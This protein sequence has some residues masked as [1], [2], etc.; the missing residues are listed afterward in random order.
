M[1]YSGV[2]GFSSISGNEAAGSILWALVSVPV[3]GLSAA[4]LGAS[5]G[6]FSGLTDGGP[7][8]GLEWFFLVGIASLLGAWGQD[9]RSDIFDGFHMAFVVPVTIASGVVGLLTWILF[10]T[11][12]TKWRHVRISTIGYLVTFLLGSTIGP[13]LGY[14][15]LLMLFVFLDD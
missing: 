2:T 7:T 12:G 8:A 4:I 14:T 1:V 5:I 9:L 10:R 3:F 6:A 13:Y 11:R 15:L